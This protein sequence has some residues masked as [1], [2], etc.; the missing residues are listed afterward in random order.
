M[1]VIKDKK[2]NGRNIFKEA[3]G[4]VCF[5]DKNSK[6]YEKAMKWKEGEIS[7]YYFKVV[8]EFPKFK[9]IDINE[10]ENVFENVELLETPE[11]KIL[12]W[13]VEGDEIVARIVNYDYTSGLDV[14]AGKE[15]AGYYENGV[16]EESFEKSEPAKYDFEEVKKYI[17]KQFVVEY[18]DFKEYI[19]HIPSGLYVIDYELPYDKYQL[20][21][22]KYIVLAE[23]G[24]RYE[25]YLALK[26]E[27]KYKRVISYAPDAIRD[28]IQNDYKKFA[29]RKMSGKWV[30]SQYVPESEDGFRRGGN[31]EVDVN[32]D[33][34]FQLAHPE[35]YRIAKEKYDVDMSGLDSFG[36]KLVVLDL[37]GAYID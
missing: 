24:E 33:M 27:L 6:H 17:K 8:K 13:R 15:I 34:I 18:K 14:V 19:K 20:K 29:Y 23:T 12:D 30:M 35:E 32:D 5:F 26:E 36:Q 25:E 2:G 28:N 7:D 31:I 3:W 9:I 37:E 10:D 4:K 1:R 21:G 16:K 22:N 11:L